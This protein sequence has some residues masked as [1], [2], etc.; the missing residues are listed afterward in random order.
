M[1]YL[2]VPQTKILQI[3][4][5]DEL[6]IRSWNKSEIEFRYQGEL[7][8][9]LQGEL[10]TVSCE[11]NLL[12]SLPGNTKIIIDKIDGNCKIYGKFENLVID[13]IPGNLEIG[14]LTNG[15][16][17]RVGGNCKIGNV[18]SSLQIEKIGGNCNLINSEGKIKFEKIGGNF[19]GFGENIQIE[20]RAVGN[21]QLQIKDFSE[22]DNQ[23][24]A[25]GNVRLYVTNGKNFSLNGSG[26]GGFQL[27]LGDELIQGKSG[28]FNKSIG[29]GQKSVILSAGGSLKISDRE[30]MSKVINDLSENDEKEWNDLEK[31]ADSHFGSTNKFDIRDLEGIDKKLDE[32]IKIKD[33]KLNK[34]IDNSGYFDSEAD[35]LLD[36]RDIKSSEHIISKPE[37]QKEAQPVTEEEKM[38]VLKLLQDKKITAEEADRLLQ[39][40]EQ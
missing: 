36:D 37:I 10:L 19:H 40:L 11:S 21:I 38:I 39:A 31:R 34:I 15:Q 30:E 4:H 7:K 35:H 22:S 9:D 13:R 14:S 12:I 6:Y 5:A 3:E 29:A 33:R 16:I 27:K 32:L 25:G 17:N 2:S 28:K 23:I 26:R 8:N 1:K 20:C 24:Q 18:I